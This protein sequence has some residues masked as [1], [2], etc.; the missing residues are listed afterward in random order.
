MHLCKVSFLPFSQIL[1]ALADYF[2]FIFRCARVSKNI[3]Q[4][5]LRKTKRTTLSIAERFTS[6]MDIRLPPAIRKLLKNAFS[7]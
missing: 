7:F 6:I 3:N 4:I 1:K 2:K 5:L